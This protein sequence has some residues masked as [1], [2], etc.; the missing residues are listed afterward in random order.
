MA[1]SEIVNH[2]QKSYCK[3]NQ[4]YCKFHALPS[5][6]KRQSSNSDFL[7]WRCNRVLVPFHSRQKG[8]V[9][10]QKVHESSI[11]DASNN[12]FNIFGGG[13]P[14]SKSDPKDNREFQE[15]FS[16]HRFWEGGHAQS[17]FI[18]IM[19]PHSFV[20]PSYIY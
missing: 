11:E 19:K 4:I 6:K 8:D 17:I 18:Y 7:K 16:C 9:A 13:P 14:P 20:S 10:T 1:K 3:Y 2:W 15:T 12:P 5:K